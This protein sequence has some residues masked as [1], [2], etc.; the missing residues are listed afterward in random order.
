MLLAV[1]VTVTP[2]QIAEA[3]GVTVI[4]GCTWAFTVSTISILSWQPAAEVAMYRMVAAPVATPV[5]RPPGAIVAIAGCRLFHTPVALAVAL[6]SCVVAPGQMVRLPVVG[7]IAGNGC[8]VTAMGGLV[9]LELTTQPAS[10]EGVSIQ[11]I[12]SPGLRVM[13]LYTVPVA[14]AGKPFSNHW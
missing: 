3:D 1:K 13:V 11:L 4:V 6:A 10:A 2:R 8:T 14:P 5:T 7:I 12:S 9:I